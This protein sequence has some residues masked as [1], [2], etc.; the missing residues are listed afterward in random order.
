MSEPVQ[1]IPPFP[2]PVE[3]FD[4]EYEA[5]QRKLRIHMV[6]ATT[7]LIALPWIVRVIFVLYASEAGHH[8]QRCY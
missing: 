5:E 6:I 8:I 1:Q 4:P 2:L 3:G 7:F